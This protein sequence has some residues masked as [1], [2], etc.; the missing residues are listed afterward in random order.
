[1]DSR[2][3]SPQVEAIAEQL[4]A[5]ES[6]LAY[7]A[8]SEVRIAYVTSEAEKHSGGKTVFAQCERIPDRFKWAI[9]Y[10]FMVTVFVPN[11]ERFTDD[12]MRIL[13]LHELLHVGIE[14]DGKEES[15]RIIP[16]DIEDF[17]LVLERYGLD[18]NQ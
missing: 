2:Y 14:V 10:D 7:I 18:W 4:L 5:S 12:Q 8:E 6:C 15:Y 3:P 11:V 9:P 13:I 1:M 17:R 16:H